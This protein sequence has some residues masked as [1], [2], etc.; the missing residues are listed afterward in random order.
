MA[1]VRDMITG[2]RNLLVE[3]YNYVFESNQKYTK[4]AKEIGIVVLVVV[5]GFGGLKIYNY[6]L[7]S[8]EATAQ[9]VFYECMREMQNARKGIGSWYDVEVAFEMGHRQNAKSK[10]APFFLI[11]KSEALNAQGKKQEALDLL[12][13][14]LK[15]LKG[16]D[17]MHSIYSV[18]RALM[19][20]DMEE[21]TI[22]K[23][24]IQELEEIGCLRAEHKKKK[25]GQIP[26]LYY[27]GSYYWNND[28]FE[29][30]KKVWDKLV[31]ISPVEP[32]SPYINLA[33]AKL[34][35]I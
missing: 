32:E 1:V 29:K 27:L 11:F 18:K 6:Y 13:N 21:E 16:D 25:A 2:V 26:A 9:K 5:A 31:S 30:A 20:M 4:Y 17:D 22:K 34:K 33:K 14:T 24:G 28:N 19:K 8:R 7:Y 10:L 15:H 35:Q 12:N 23:E 3:S